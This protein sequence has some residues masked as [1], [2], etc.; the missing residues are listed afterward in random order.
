MVARAHTPCEIPLLPGTPLVPISPA[1]HLRVSPPSPAARRY[2]LATQ[3]LDPTASQRIRRRS[4][5]SVPASPP[6][7]AKATSAANPT[8]PASTSA[9][10]TSPTAETPSIAPAPAAPESWPWSPPVASLAAASAGNL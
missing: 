5:P 1:P 8:P 4:V 3:V 2:P 7:P 6:L 9:P 10:K